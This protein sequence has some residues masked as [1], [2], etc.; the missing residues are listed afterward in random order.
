M[1]KFTADPYTGVISERTV[2]SELFHVLIQPLRQ[3]MENPVFIILCGNQLKFIV[4]RHQCRG[5]DIEISTPVM[6]A[7]SRQCR[8]VQDRIGR[9]DSCKLTDIH[10]LS[11]I[12][13]NC[14]VPHVFFIPDCELAVK[15]TERRSRG[16]ID[17]VLLCSFAHGKKSLRSRCSE[18]A[19][20]KFSHFDQV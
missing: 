9:L 17:P 13:E 7:E 18:S 1:P 3:R 16:K 11:V 14:S 12:V 10:R 5:V 6:A 19:V 4:F 15:V 20:F 8:P 2:E